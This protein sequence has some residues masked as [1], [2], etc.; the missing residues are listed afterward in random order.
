MDYLAIV[1]KNDETLAKIYHSRRAAESFIACNER[2]NDTSEIK[3]YQESG[4]A[5]REY[6]RITGTNYYKV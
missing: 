6:N 3:E 5:Q 2:K 1:Y 4:G